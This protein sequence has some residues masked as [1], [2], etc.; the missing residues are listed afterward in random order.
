VEPADD[1]DLLADPEEDLFGTALRT[2]G[3][4]YRILALMPDDPRSN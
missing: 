3:G 1:V 2:K 4:S